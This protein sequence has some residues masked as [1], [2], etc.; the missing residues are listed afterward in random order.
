MD[1]L[2]DFVNAVGAMTET[3]WLFRSTLRDKGVPDD[4]ATELTKA[5][6][7]ELLQLTQHKEDN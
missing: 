1:N 4:D 5:F 2:K 7:H 6:M 3:T